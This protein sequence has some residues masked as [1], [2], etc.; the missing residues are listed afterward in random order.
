MHRGALQGVDPLTDQPATGS[1]LDDVSA[2]PIVAP[3]GTILFGT[4]NRYN[5][6]QVI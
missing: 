3:D 1:V 4:W 5:Y 2:K 6:A